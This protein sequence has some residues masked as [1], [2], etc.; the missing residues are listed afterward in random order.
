MVQDLPRVAIVGLN[1][2]PEPTGIAPYTSGLAAGLAAFGWDVNVVTAF[3]HYPAWR[4]SDAYE[5]HKIR[6]TLSGVNVTRIR[7]YMPKN[8]SGIKRLILEVGFGVGASLVRW[9]RPDVV[10][11]VSPALFATGIALLRA[12]L[13]PGRP[14]VIIWVQD[15]YSVGVKET[16]ALGARSASLMT[17][18]ESLVLKRAHAVVVIHERFRRFVTANLGVRDQDVRVV[19]N[20]THFEALSVDRNQYRDKFGWGDEFVVLHAGN[21]G[22][23]QAL[24]N[25]IEAARLADLHG[26]PVRFVLLGDGNQREQL[27]RLAQ[28]VTKITFLSSL[29]DRDFQGAM[30]AADVLLVNERPGVSEMAVPSKLTS[31]FAAMKPVIVATDAGSITADELSAAGAGLRVDAGDPSALLSAALDMASDPARSKSFGQRGKTFQ[32]SV[33]APSTAIAHYAEIITS[34]AK[35]RGR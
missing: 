27:A 17:R 24:E 22:A 9:G 18:A 14:A 25:V 4:I 12:R 3:P 15:L 10:V 6:E 11:L 8:P 7:P 19:R 16:G 35:R 34:L 23:K 20:W 28:G 31:Y 2:L 26:E 13:T 29:D 33:L 5:G 21:M 32:E 30:A 1:Y